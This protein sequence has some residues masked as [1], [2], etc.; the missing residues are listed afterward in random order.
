MARSPP[1]VKYSQFGFVKKG[2]YMKTYSEEEALC[3]VKKVGEIYRLSAQRVDYYVYA[4]CVQENQVEYDDSRKY[5]KKVE[6][7]LENCKPT[8][9]IIIRRDF[10]EIN[11]TLWYRSYFGR[12]Q[13]YR[14]RKEAIIEF[15]NCLTK[16]KM[17]V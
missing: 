14:L 3:I 12:S 16:P 15:V 17:L 7:V 1:N 2:E 13:Y 4:N 10:L 8:T 9:R 5:V 11:D 6:Q